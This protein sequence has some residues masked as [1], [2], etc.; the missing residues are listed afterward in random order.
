[1]SHDYSV[2]TIIRDNDAHRA[3]FVAQSPSLDDQVTTSGTGSA[4]AGG[5]NEHEHVEALVPGPWRQR[6]VELQMQRDLELSSTRCSRDH[7]RQ[8]ASGPRRR[9]PTLQEL[10]VKTISERPWLIRDNNLTWVSEENCLQILGVLMKKIEINP[11]LSHGI[12]QHGTRKSTRVS[13]LGRWLC[14]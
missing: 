2:F 7:G 1:M 14:V 12:P 4:S 3:S 13:A 6:F 5:E 10:C 11:S 9:F 8:P